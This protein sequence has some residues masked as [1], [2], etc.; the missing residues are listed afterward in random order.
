MEVNLSL[1][2]EGKYWVPL[3]APLPNPA[4]GQVTAVSNL[5]TGSVTSVPPAPA[6]RARVRLG[7]SP[8]SRRT[9][10]G[11]GR[12]SG[13]AE[14]P[15]TPALQGPEGRRRVPTLRPPH[16]LQAGR[17]AGSRT[18]PSGAGTQDDERSGRPLTTAGAHLLWRSCFYSPQGGEGTFWDLEARGPTF[19]CSEI[20]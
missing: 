9:G 2:K 5:M 13:G 18:W 15:A 14:R 11:D 3:W 17:G 20:I 4:R 8:T 19:G 12:L 6:P 1:P 7:L 16:G 10:R